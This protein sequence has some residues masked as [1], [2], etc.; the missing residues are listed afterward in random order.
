MSSSLP[1]TACDCLNFLRSEPFC[2]LLAHL[3]GLDLVKD[4]QRHFPQLITRYTEKGMSS[5]E[6]IELLSSDE[7]GGKKT[8]AKQGSSQPAKDSGELEKH[9]T[10]KM[11]S[12]AQAREEQVFSYSNRTIS[13]SMEDLIPYTLL[14]TRLIV[15][16]VIKN[17]FSFSQ[18]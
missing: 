16:I 8:A 17:R 2:L 11:V 7:E 14:F 13:L 15:H 4:F 6:P 3:T 9:A 5:D 12:T 1:A 18:S 10:I